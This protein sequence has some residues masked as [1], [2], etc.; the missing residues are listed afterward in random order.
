MTGTS[1]R[2]AISSSRSVSSTSSSRQPSPLTD[3]DAEQLDAACLQ[4]QQIACKLEPAGPK[5]SWSMMT[6]ALR[7]LSLGVAAV[8]AGQTQQMAS[9]AAMRAYK[10]GGLSAV[11]HVGFSPLLCPI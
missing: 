2:S 11:S 6:K 4:Q 1:V 8:A 3:G 5:A 10:H 7:D 9:V